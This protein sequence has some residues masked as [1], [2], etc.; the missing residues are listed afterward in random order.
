MTFTMK[1][2]R[3]EELFHPAN[4]GLKPSYSYV[5]TFE[6]VN[7][8]HGICTENITGISFLWKQREENKRE[9]S[10]AYVKLDNLLIIPKYH[11]DEHQEKEIGL[12]SL[13]EGILQASYEG[14]I[15]DGVPVDLKLE[16]M[17]K[18]TSSGAMISKAD[19]MSKSDPNCLQQQK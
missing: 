2:G 7:D 6:F 5:K 12:I 17:T 14:K 8:E 16:R 4:G 18:K 15:Q 13:A 3:K 1:N 19:P 10:E 9:A 11:L